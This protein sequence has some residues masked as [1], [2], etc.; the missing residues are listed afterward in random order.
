MLSNTMVPKY[1]GEFRD[2][3]LRGE[4]RVCENISLQMNRIDDDIANPDYFYDPNAIDGYVRFCEAELTLTDGTDLTLLPTFKMWAED[5]LSWYYYSEEDTIDPATG[6]RIT[7]RKKRRLRNKQY[8]IIARGNSKSLYETTIQAYGLLTDTKTT[9]QITTAPTMAQAEEVMMPFSTAIAKSRGPL[10]SVL[11][12]GSNKS[13][14]QY[15]QAK[16]ASTKKGIENKITNSYVEI[17]PMRIDKLQGSR[18]KYCTVDEWLSGDVKE[19]VIGALE[20]SA[21]KG[22]VD[23]YIILAVSSEGTV[24]DSVGDS[25]KMELLKILRGEYEDPHTSI[26]YYRLDD[27]NEVNDPSAWVK[28]SPNIG[29]TVSYDAYMRDVKRAEAN[30]ATR[31]DILAKRFGI[32]VEG[33]TYF[34]TYDEIQRHPYQNYDKLPCSMGMDASQGDDFWAFTWV[35]PL[36]GERFGIKTRSYVSESKY[37]KLPSATRHKY[38]G[39]QQEGTLVIM[40]GSLLDWVAVYEDVRDYIHSHD[41]AILSFGFDP[42]NA[43]AFVDRWCMENGEYGVETVRQGVKTESVPLGEIKALAEARQLIFDEELMK[44]AMGN[45]VA[46]QDNNGNYKL[47][48][49]RSDEKIDNVAALM[50]AWVAMTRNREMFM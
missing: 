15:T 32:P 18:A 19:D 34:F 48:K 50:D 28:A 3:V 45:S 25:I 46:L 24:R 14:S 31:N 40:P 41:W 27:L 39:L 8:L 36:G 30:P 10:F 42:Y 7:V 12:D 35:F 11:T 23:D 44:F 33:Y 13:R 2:S 5:L 38:D 20:Q 43:G 37:Q 26:W 21:A 17:R 16:L 1:Y 47:D 9:Q 4:T 49:R 29:V 22:G 6:R